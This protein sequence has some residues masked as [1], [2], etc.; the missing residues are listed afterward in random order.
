MP[1]IQICSEIQWM[2][3]KC[4]LIEKRWKEREGRGGEAREALCGTAKLGSGTSSER[5]GKV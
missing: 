4:F 5:R 3:N 2:A 1:E